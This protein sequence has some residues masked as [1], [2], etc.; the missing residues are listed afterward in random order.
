MSIV[1]FISD[2]GLK[3]YYS[4][5]IKGALLTEN[6]QLNLVDISHNVKTYDIVQ[7]AYIL[8]NAYTH[9]PEGTIHIVSV[10]N[11]YS[12]DHCFLAI[13]HNGHYFIGPDNGLFSLAFGDQELTDIYELTF[14]KKN[15]NPLGDVFAKGVKHILSELPFNEIGIPIESIDK[16]ISIQPVTTKNRIRGAVI[17]IDNY[18]NAITNISEELIEKI[19]QG[20]PFKIYFK[21]HEPL[22]DIKKNYAEVPIGE[23]LGLINSANHL[24]IAINMG[25]AASM[26]GLSIDEHIQIDFEND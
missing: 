6:P 2:F 22:N 5:V 26:L 23:I 3:D 16:R 7:G 11:Y 18:E 9:F 1:T 15:E 12:T 17:H 21:R 13:R 10:N 25:K 4:A 8:K 19:G 20:R 24:E 14:D